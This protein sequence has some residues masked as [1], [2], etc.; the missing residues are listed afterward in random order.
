MIT[1]SR[2]AL[3][4]DMSWPCQRGCE[5]V[6]E[7]INYC[8]GEPTELQSKQVETMNERYLQIFQN[9]MSDQFKELNLDE[10]LLYLRNH[11][12]NFLFDRSEERRVGKEC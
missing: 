9:G 8:R 12:H 5:H 6:I 11:I 10:M 3:S 7:S 4:P 1:F 2:P